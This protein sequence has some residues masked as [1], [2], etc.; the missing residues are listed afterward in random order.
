ME[1]DIDRNEGE[2]YQPS[3]DFAPVSKSSKEAEALDYLNKIL[4]GEIAAVEAYAKAIEKFPQDAARFE[5]ASFRQDH[6]NNV[7][8]LTRLLKTQGEDPS[9]TSGAWGTTVA[10][11]M[12]MATFIGDKSAVGLLIEGEEHGLNQYSDVLNFPVP[13]SIRTKISDSL[14]PQS[15]V[16][17]GKL[18][19]IANVI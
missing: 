17:V 8:E 12:N 5:L 15:R 1:K 11:L 16:N 13:E 3:K 4:R 19:S 18:R 10:G 9:R 2:I 14:L 7:L 6:Q